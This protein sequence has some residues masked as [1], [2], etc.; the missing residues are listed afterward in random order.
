ML[1]EIKSHNFPLFAVLPQE[2]QVSESS[3]NK[4]ISTI[5]E[6]DEPLELRNEPTYELLLPSS[7]RKLHFVMDDLKINTLNAN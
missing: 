1:V 2:N 4:I 6:T 3:L 5:D 7:W